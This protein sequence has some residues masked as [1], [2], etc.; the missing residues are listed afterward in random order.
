M[1]FLQSSLEL[2]FA[3]NISRQEVDIEILFDEEREIRESFTVRLEPDSN[4]IADLGVYWLPLLNWM[5][6]LVNCSA[7]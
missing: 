6:S 7:C 5:V 4:M 1:E 3:V 2:E